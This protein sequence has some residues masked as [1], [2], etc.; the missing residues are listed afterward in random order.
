MVALTTQVYTIY[1]NS[2]LQSANFDDH[3]HCTCSSHV[4]KILSYGFKILSYGFAQVV[5][6]PTKHP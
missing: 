2:R 3:S 6:L 5:R 1:S 4:I